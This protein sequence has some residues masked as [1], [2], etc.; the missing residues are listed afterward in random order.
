MASEEKFDP[1]KSPVDHLTIPRLWDITA[2]ARRV[3]AKRTSEEVKSAQ[4]TVDGWLE[5]FFETVFEEE[6]SRLRRRAEE[7]DRYSM[8]FFHVER[9]AYGD[10]WDDY[11]YDIGRFN[12]DKREDLDIPHE[13]STTEAEALDACIDWFELSETGFGE[14]SEPMFFAALALKHVEKALHYV[15]EW[16]DPS[17]QW[18][19]ADT[20]EVE[21][22]QFTKKLI[23]ASGRDPNKLPRP[24]NFLFR[25]ACEAAVDAMEAIT[26]AEKFA[27]ANWLKKQ[28]ANVSKQAVT[29]AE[30]EQRERHEA[31]EARKKKERTALM[32]G[33]RE[34][35][36]KEALSL[37][38]ADWEIETSRFQ[39]AEKAGEYY[40]HWLK[41]F[42]EKSFDYAPTTCRD[43]I[44]DRAKE[45][46]VKWR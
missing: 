23:E 27:H 21:L 32:N 28:L 29:A 12:D 7:G 45:I 36:R 42:P 10:H 40:S 41:N 34:A 6:V 25:S 8:E 18:K 30:K 26:Y 46:G 2:R 9:H 43:W 38:L 14:E 33:K 16:M 44:R 4:E 24:V 1:M 20:M 31:E 22:Y 5:V 15:A 35:K 19:A 11:L 37:V 3:L 39:S 17:D 13:G